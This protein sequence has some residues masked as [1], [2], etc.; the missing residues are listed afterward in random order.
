[1]ERS[2][3]AHVILTDKATRRTSGLNPT[4]ASTSLLE[5][6]QVTPARFHHALRPAANLNM[7][8]RQGQRSVHIGPL[9]LGLTLSRFI[10]LPQTKSYRRRLHRLSDVQFYAKQSSG[11]SD[12]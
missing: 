6:W 3:S 8:R 10:R 9:T 1:M 5:Y 4:A 11:L 12:H 2:A 7:L